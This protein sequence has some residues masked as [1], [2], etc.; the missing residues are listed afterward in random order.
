MSLTAIDAFAGA[1]GWDLALKELGI[2]PLGIELDEA[3]CATREA[4]GLRT[5]Q[6]DVAHVNPTIY[7][8]ADL[9]IAS[10]PCPTYSSAG[11][12]GG[13]HLTEIVIRCLHELA[14][15]S[16]TRAERRQEAFEVLDPIYWKAERRKAIKKGRQPDYAKATD[17]ALRDASMSLLVVEPLRWVLALK[18][19]FIALEQ[20]PGV[21]GLWSVMAEIL[22]ALGYYTWTGIMEAERYG[23][24]QTRERAIL[25]ADREQPVHP[26]RPTHQRYV[27]GEPQRHDMS[28]DGEVLPWVSMEDVGLRA[29]VVNTRGDRKTPGGNEFA[30]DRPSWALTEK[31]RSWVLQTNQRPGGSDEYLQRPASTPSPTLLGN[32]RNWK[33]RNGNQENAA[34]R[35][36]D[37]PAP[38]VCFGHN[39]NKVEWTDDEESR[40]VELWEAAVL[41]SFP[42]DYPV[43]GSRSKQ[44]LQVGNA[45]P[46]LLA[47]A[48]L[49]QL[50]S[51]VLQ[52]PP[53]LASTRSGGE[54]G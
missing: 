3:A 47:R 14:A 8:P 42:A 51:P 36:S 23:V 31:T 10:P 48:I 43:Q 53:A 19:R 22:G 35:A 38:T 17:R 26:P 15:G 32:G 20:V 4:A 21:L 6:A 46:P 34:V 28:F 29:G 13:R 50:L 11:N 41:Q 54:L 1:G 45:V 2:D 49:T 30:T 39:L 16:E 52:E 40:P 44:F 24:P 18:P 27:K 37:E 7:G 5:L 9:F 12:G 25:M 33:W